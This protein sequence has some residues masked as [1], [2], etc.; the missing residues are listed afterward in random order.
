MLTFHYY[1]GFSCILVT[2]TSPGT[3][4]FQVDSIVAASLGLPEKFD[5][6][7]D[8]R[9]EVFQAPVGKGAT[10]TRGGHHS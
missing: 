8:V 9:V 7:W 1:K 6:Q 4:S 5:Y 10:K 2:A 3:E